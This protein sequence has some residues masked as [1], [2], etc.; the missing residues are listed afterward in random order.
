MHTH[1]PFIPSLRQALRRQTGA[2]GLRSILENLL[3]D[4]MFEVK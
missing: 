4:A 2:R 1:S 3:K